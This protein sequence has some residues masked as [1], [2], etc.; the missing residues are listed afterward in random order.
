MSEQV[1]LSAVAQRIIIKFLTNEIVKPPEILM[2][3]RAQFGDETL[4]RIQVQDW[5]KSFKEG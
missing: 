3:L 1:V 5:S 4:S 2:R